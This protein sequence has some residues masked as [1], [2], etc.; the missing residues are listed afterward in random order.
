[1]TIGG[2]AEGIARRRT[3]VT[4]WTLARTLGWRPT[5][6]TGRGRPAWKPGR[7]HSEARVSWRGAEWVTRRWAPTRRRAAWRHKVGRPTG[8]SAWITRRWH[9]RVG[10]TWE[11][12]LAVDAGLL[13]PVLSKID[14]DL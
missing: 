2:G 10:S 14:A 12:E 9:V 11:K 8:R 7:G 1:M 5:G 3:A 4:I 6:H 13:P